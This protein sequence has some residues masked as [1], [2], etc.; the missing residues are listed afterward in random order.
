MVRPGFAL[1]LAAA[2]CQA[3]PIP[4][5]WGLNPE[6]LRAG[7]RLETRFEGTTPCAVVVSPDKSESPAS[8]SQTLDAAPYRGK[9]VRFSATLRTEQRPGQ[10]NG[11]AK[12]WIHVNRPAQTLGLFDNPEDHPVRTFEWT[13][14]EIALTV[15]SDA[16]TVTFGITSDQT[17]A[18]WVKDVSLLVITGAE[19]VLLPRDPLNLGFA[20]GSGSGTPLNW[21]LLADNPGRSRYKAEVVH[22]GCHV[23]PPCVSLA[24]LPGTPSDERVVLLQ[25]FSAANYRGK[26]VRFRGLL[27]L[28]SAGSGIHARLFLRTGRPGENIN[29]VTLED[30][31]DYR[32]IRTS[33]WTP[34]EVIRKIDDDVQDIAI[35]II[36]TGGGR[37]WI[38]EVA[39]AVLPDATT[40]LPAVP[41]SVSLKSAGTSLIPEALIPKALIPEAP[42]LSAVATETAVVL[43][44][45]PDSGWPS[46]PKPA[47]GAQSQ[48]LNAAS[49]LAA[50]YVRDLPNFLCTLLIRRAENLNDSG[51]K[52]RDS[53]R[54]QLGFADG[55]EHYRLLSVNEMPV[56]RPYRSIGGAISEGDFGSLLAEIFRPRSAEFHWDHWARLRNRIVQVYRYEITQ[57]KSAYELQF[58]GAKGQ[59]LTAVT[60]HHGYVYIERDSSYILRIEQVAD[61]PAKFPIRAANTVIDYDWNDVGGQQY[62]LPLRAEVTMDT[63]A[64]R[65]LNVVE[66]RDYRKFTA[67]TQ[68]RFDEP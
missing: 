3:E 17:G 51:W 40:A 25:D 50:A 12:L 45:L 49:G 38:D 9:T 54:V 20:D 61:P 46:L 53:L 65:S 63:S 56:N 1:L 44:A 66:F 22:R 41:T 60:A 29:P 28:Q 19:S 10:T 43:P 4:A 47:F 62:L 35:G 34:A 55:R 68:I 16:E 59:P 6:A 11:G 8:L 5:T 39:F 42:S 7:F 14:S 15:N 30:H 24:S 18:A 23:G 57:P 27:R 21:T 67:D 58:A 36:L 32:E 33:D 64:L 37:V 2:W 31:L 48:S 13:R 52:G 26:T